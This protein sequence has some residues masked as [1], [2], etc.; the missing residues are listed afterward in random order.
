MQRSHEH[1]CADALAGSFNQEECGSI[2]KGSKE[3]PPTTE[4]AVTYLP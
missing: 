4:D 1:G 2:T 3:L